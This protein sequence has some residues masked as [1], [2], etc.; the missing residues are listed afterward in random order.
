MVGTPQK[1]ITTADQAKKSI[2]KEAKINLYK[3]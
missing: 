1:Y 3:K 2:L